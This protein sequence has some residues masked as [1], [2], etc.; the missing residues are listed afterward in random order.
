MK[1]FFILFV[2]IP[3]LSFMFFF[4]SIIV[5]R[6]TPQGIYERKSE[7]AKA[8]DDKNIYWRMPRWQARWWVQPKNISEMIAVRVNKS[9]LDF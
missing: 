6:V 7:R 2:G 8:P 9:E 5:I 3:I 1:G 4:S